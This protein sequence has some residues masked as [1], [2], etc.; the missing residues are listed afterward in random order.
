MAYPPMA[1][2]SPTSIGCKIWEGERCSFVSMGLAGD[3]LRTYTTLKHATAIKL[4]VT[5]AN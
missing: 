3:Q 1:F 4:S 2:G 5:A